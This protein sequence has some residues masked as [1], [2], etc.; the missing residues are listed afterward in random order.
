VRA[1]F[2]ADFFRGRLSN[3]IP[4]TTRGRALF[5]LQLLQN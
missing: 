4:L 2:T 5:M 3:I 1:T